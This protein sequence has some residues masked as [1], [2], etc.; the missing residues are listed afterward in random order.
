MLKPIKIFKI[1]GVPV[2]RA[3]VLF[4]IIVGS[5]G[6]PSA[7]SCEIF[8]QGIGICING[9]APDNPPPPLPTI[10]NLCNNTSSTL[11]VA[12]AYSSGNQGWMSKGW[13]TINPSDCERLNIGNYNGDIYLYGENAKGEL[14]PGSD[15]YFCI[16]DSVDF[17]FANANTRNCSGG[18]L[19]KVGM[20]K[21]RVRS[22]ENSYNFNNFN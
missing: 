3:S 4:S 21:W 14:Y 18:I 12:R 9:Q 6:A 2:V 19:K 17:T 16:N 7:R 1:L 11:N 5:C 20:K 13:T 22:G 15:A 8:E 10:L